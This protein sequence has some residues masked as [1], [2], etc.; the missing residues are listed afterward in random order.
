[1]KKNITFAKLKNVRLRD[2]VF[3]PRLEQW[4]RVTI[5]SVIEKTVET[6]RIDAFDL[7]WKEGMEKKPHYFWDSDVAKVMEGIAYDLALEK[8]DELEKLY[9]GWVKKIC[10]A[11]QEDGYLNSC[12]SSIEPE[13]RF[14]NLAS[15]H[16]LYCA[17]HL[18]E[19]AVAGYEELGK[20]ELLECL[21]RYADYLC[22]TFGKEEGKRRGWP[23]HEEIELALAKLYK[24]TGKKS[25]LDLMRYFIDD[26]GTE[27][28]FFLE[29]GAVRNMTIIRNQQ[30]AEPVRDLAEAYGHAVRCVYLL[31]GMADLAG[32]DDDRT[33]FD[34][35]ERL[36]RD[37]TERKMYITGG[38]GSSFSGECFSCSYDLSNGSLMYAESC[39]AMGLALFVSRMFLL[40]GEGKY[41]D[42]LEKCLYNG[43]LSGISF[44]GDK[45]FYTNYLEVDENLQTYNFGAKTR[46][47]F[48]SCSC[49]PTSFA[50]FLP[51]IGKFLYSI[52]GEK[53]EICLNIPA[54]NSAQLE[55]AGKTVLLEVEGDYPYD[56]A[57]RIR[58]GSEEEFALRLRIPSWCRK[59][60]VKLN[61]EKAD[62]FLPKRKWRKGDEVELLLDMPPRFVYADSRVTGN[63]GRCA[64]L[65]GPVVYALEELD[66]T[67]PVREMILDRSKALKIV[68]LPSS[69]PEG[70]RGA[71]IAGKAFRE[72]RES[73][74]LY[75][76]EPGVYEETNFLAVPY[77]LWQN[78]GETNMAVWVRYMQ[79]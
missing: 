46:Q 35:C 26:R 64:I 70:I 27:P 18:M 19:A 79:K 38:I 1:M 52:D 45:F 40:T 67:C 14:T 23:G 48:F 10:S 53:E 20:T 43:I 60:E 73:A 69:F 62:S 37:I 54:A 77:A 66:Q 11:Q 49:C 33:L 7:A 47:E 63:C 55:L 50:R 78:R 5:P 72:K 76:E 68:P 4:K 31:C 13:K 9:D 34:A 71:A 21:C 39:A 25:Y 51:Q 32:L 41:M 30:A 29:E 58:I 8:N 6:G 57:V 3:G 42:V 59:Y 61:G 75:T 2:G 56:G 15:K 17:G 36:F 65:R 12:I 28:N 44:H 22:R 16:E 24:V 74:S